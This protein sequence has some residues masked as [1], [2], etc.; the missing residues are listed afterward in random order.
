MVSVSVPNWKGNF[1]ELP[2]LH[3]SCQKEKKREEIRYLLKFKS[4]AKNVSMILS[5]NISYISVDWA[6][7]HT[8][9]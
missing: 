9:M 3:L 2:Q 8:K 1:V 5:K 7:K 6:K 4:V